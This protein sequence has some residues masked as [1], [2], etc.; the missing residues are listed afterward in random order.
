MTNRRSSMGDHVTN[1][2]SSMGDHMTNRVSSM[3]GHMTNRH[4]PLVLFN[5]ASS[6]HLTHTWRKVISIC[7]CCAPAHA[8]AQSTFLSLLH[9][10]LKAKK[11]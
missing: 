4:T 8:W 7:E 6:P 11:P 2:G 1:R 5:L 3:G 10:T 9:E